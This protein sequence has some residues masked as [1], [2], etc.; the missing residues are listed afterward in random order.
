[1]ARLKA[2]ENKMTPQTVPVTNFSE[3]QGNMVNIDR[4]V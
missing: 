1:M 4:Y 3:V 2:A